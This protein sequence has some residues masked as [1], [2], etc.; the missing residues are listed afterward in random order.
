MAVGLSVNVAA[1]PRPAEQLADVD[2]GGRRVTV[3]G[4]GR[5]GGGVAAVR[6][7]ARRG[8]RVTV[9]D[10]ADAEAL[11]DSLGELADLHLDAVHLGP[12][13]PA[14][15]QTEFVVVNPAVRPANPSLGAARDAGARLISEAELF[16]EACPAQVI[17]VTGANGKTTTCAMLHAML[18]D[19]GRRAWLGGNIGRSLLGDLDSMSADDFV[20]LEL[21]SFQLAHL[22][23]TC[24]MPQLAVVTN[25]S[26]NHLDWHGG[27]ANYRASK[28][29]LVSA[30]AAV[31][32][33][34]T[35]GEV[36]RCA[37]SPMVVSSRVGRWSACPRWPCRVS[38]IARTP[39]ARRQPPSSP[40]WLRET[41]TGRW[42]NSVGCRTAWNIWEKSAVDGFSTIRS[43]PRPL[44]RWRHW[45]PSMVLC[46]YWPAET[47][48][49]RTCA[50]WEWWWPLAWMAQHCSAP[51]ARRCV[52]QF[53]MRAP[54]AKC[55]WTSNWP[56]RLTGVAGNRASAI[57]SCSRPVV[58]VTTSFATISIGAKR[59]AR[60]LSN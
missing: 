58:Q 54:T 19:S 5:H 37:D 17:G 45:R 56:R 40:A 6:Y 46:G 3:M 21:S 8:A 39:R 59:S 27:Y 23:A 49:A 43:P 10:T 60:W 12:H 2:W 35:D 22:S 55:L 25:C 48:K 33:N 31:V 13:R 44:Q 16:L 53:A 52:R 34:E 50:H 41:S 42:G 20:V 30:S 4:L 24:R 14:D 7:L 26:P 32:F 1:L 36:L 18:V 57:R 29:K 51:P 15:F 9:S 38:T 47:P 28:Q 11:A